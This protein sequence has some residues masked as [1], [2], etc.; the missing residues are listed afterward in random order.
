M[1]IF[2]ESVI[3]LIEKLH[4]PFLIPQDELRSLQKIAKELEI[5]GLT[6][7]L[8]GTTNGTDVSL[9]GTLVVDAP[10]VAPSVER[11]REKAEESE[12]S[13][14]RTKRRRQDKSQQIEA[15]I[16]TPSLPPNPPPNQKSQCLR[17]SVG[18]T[19]MEDTD[20][21]SESSMSRE[22]R[23][24]KDNIQPEDINTTPSKKNIPSLFD[25]KVEPDWEFYY[26][27]KQLLQKK[28][29][30]Q[31]P[32]AP[33]TPQPSQVTAETE[34]EQTVRVSEPDASSSISEV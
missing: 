20:D 14:P 29:E 30:S 16:A 5:K 10:V 6:E 3:F 21:M 26:K 4:F 33:Q 24:R 12:T 25:V 9:T 17:S 23:R 11:E 19:D 1:G 8:E 34:R 32:K 22:K 2:H 31:P 15:I 28:N 7:V 13:T 27:Q 18:N